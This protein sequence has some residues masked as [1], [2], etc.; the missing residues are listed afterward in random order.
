MLQ[1]FAFVMFV[2]A[3]STEESTSGKTTCKQPHRAV[4]CAFYL[5]YGNPETDGK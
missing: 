1:W 4:H 5:W 3:M 2:V